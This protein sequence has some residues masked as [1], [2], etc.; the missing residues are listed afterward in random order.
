MT[1]L[2]SITLTLFLVMDPLGNVPLFLAALR[3]TPQGRRQ[4]VIARELIIALLI[5][6][7]FL[8]VGGRLLS[9]L[10]IT[11]E[12]MQLASGVIL[13][14]IAIRMM[15]PEQQ[16]SLSERVIAEPFIVPL[17]VP[18]VAGPTVLVTEIV[19]VQREAN[20]W[21]MVLAGLLIAWVASAVILYCSGYLQ[22][23]LGERTLVAVERL[24]GMLLVIL[25]V[26]AMLDGVLRVL[27][28]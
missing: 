28:P 4:R 18:Y 2:L 22:R 15:F 8:V 20:S 16:G 6:L 21:L 5:M 9:L 3:D 1:Q 23:W 26:Q 11:S 19:L 10:Q 17:A 14:L 13:F 12:A 25:A 27:R 7:A 24:M